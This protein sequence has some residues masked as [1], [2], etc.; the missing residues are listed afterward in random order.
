ME[1]QG[2]RRYDVGSGGTV[3][4]TRLEPPF[5]FA[6]H[7]PLLHFK[8]FRFRVF[9]IQRVL[10]ERREHESNLLH[11]FL[12]QI[13]LWHA[14]LFMARCVPRNTPACCSQQLHLVRISAVGYLHT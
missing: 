4:V 13:S 3:E 14:C 7:L 5:L 9:F 12:E 1:K 8:C 10:S 2:S 6:Q 11:S